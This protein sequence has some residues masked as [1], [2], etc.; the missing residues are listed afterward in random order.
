[1]LS[2]EK[3]EAGNLQISDEE[4]KKPL[5]FY[6]KQEVDFSQLSDEEARKQ[7]LDV[8]DDMSRRIRICLWKEFK[9]YLFIFAAAVI[10]SKIGR[11]LGAYDMTIG[12]VGLTSLNFGTILDFLCRCLWRLRKLRRSA[13]NYEVQDYRAQLK[14]ACDFRDVLLESGYF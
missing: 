7:L 4:E 1:M 14:K 6:K 8:Y 5:L 12:A 2:D 11:L 10:L 9:K 3:Q 13:V